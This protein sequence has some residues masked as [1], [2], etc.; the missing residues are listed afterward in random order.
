MREKAR[1]TEKPWENQLPALHYYSE[2]ITTESNGTLASGTIVFG[3]LEGVGGSKRVM[4]IMSQ[5]YL[6]LVCDLCCHLSSFN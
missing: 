4:V 1:K 6:I 5:Y 2:A 3:A